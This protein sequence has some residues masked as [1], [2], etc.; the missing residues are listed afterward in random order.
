M[1]EALDKAELAETIARVRRAMPRNADVMAVCAKAE[2]LSLLLWRRQPAMV[3]AQAAEPAKPSRPARD[4]RGYMRDYMR[5][6]RK[7]RAGPK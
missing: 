7:R 5:G 3:V 2:E 6:Y 1:G 4:R